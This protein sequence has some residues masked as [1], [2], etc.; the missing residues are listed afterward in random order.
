[1]CVCVCVYGCVHTY[2]HVYGCVH[3]CGL[4]L[5]ESR[6]KVSWLE[7]G[8]LA[9]EKVGGNGTGEDRCG[10]AKSGGH[11]GGGKGG[12]MRRVLASCCY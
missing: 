10:G 9:E 4:G 5:L 12:M 1:V 2:A 7:E 6:A 3:M 8:T 11:R